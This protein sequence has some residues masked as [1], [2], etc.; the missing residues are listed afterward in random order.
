MDKHSWRNLKKRRMYV[1]NVVMINIRTS[2]QLHMIHIEQNITVCV[3]SLDVN[4]FS[5]KL[6][7]LY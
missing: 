6:P 1:N 3:M 7:V 5:P 2:Y 4:F